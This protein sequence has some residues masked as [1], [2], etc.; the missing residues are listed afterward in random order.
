MKA[1][2][3]LLLGATFFVSVSQASESPVAVQTFEG[4]QPN[5]DAVFANSLEQIAGAW[6]AFPVGTAIRFNDDGTADF[7]LDMAGKVVGY[8][9]RTWF[10][11]RQLFIAFTNFDG[12]SEGCGTD[13]GRYTVQ[14]LENSSIAFESIGDTCRFRSNMLGGHPATDSELRFQPAQ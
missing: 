9:A 11:G 10:E 12:E 7:G 13:I 5:D 4:A 8:S 2:L 1:I 3:I 6:Y 14:L